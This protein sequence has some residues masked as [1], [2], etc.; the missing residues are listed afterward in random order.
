MTQGLLHDIA[1]K[2][3]HGFRNLT[4]KTEDPSPEFLRYFLE[5]FLKE[6]VL[7]EH[8]NCPLDQLKDD[9]IMG[10]GP[11]RPY[12]YATVTV[13]KEGYYTLKYYP[14]SGAFDPSKVEVEFSAFKKD[15][16]EEA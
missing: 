10:T 8:P 12:E 16:A 1:D 9:Y 13:G 5:D 4:T 7:K 6:K 3:E 14:E 15:Q 2:L 11:N